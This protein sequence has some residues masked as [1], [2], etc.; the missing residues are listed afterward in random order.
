MQN[1]AAAIV[2]VFIAVPATF[3]PFPR[4]RAVSK[5][6]FP[7]PVRGRVELLP[8]EEDQPYSS[9]SILLCRLSL[10]P[11]LSTSK[12]AIGYFQSEEFP[13]LKKPKITAQSDERQTY[14]K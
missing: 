9:L 3:C 14:I 4:T 12:R 11:V 1:Q 2:A 13:I 10:S 6:F 5:F 8:Q 7:I